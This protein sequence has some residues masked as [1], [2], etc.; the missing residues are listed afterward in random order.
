MKQVAFH[1]APIGQ[2]NLWGNRE[3][4]SW[5]DWGYPPIFWYD[6]GV[7]KKVF[8]MDDIKNL[9]IK[10]LLLPHRDAIM[11][12]AEAYRV[13]NI[14]V[15]GSV[16]RGEATDESDID[17]LVNFPIGYKL[18]DHI[19]FVTDLKALLGRHVDVVI[20]QHLRDEYRPYILMDVIPL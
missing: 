6:K 12:L 8:C 3:D 5:A 17:L 19:H 9:G 16:A 10:D 14:R 15:F 4:E 11:R 2:P 7:I 18:R 20:E 13:T 1:H